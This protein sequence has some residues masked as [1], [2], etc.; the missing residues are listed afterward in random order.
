MQKNETKPTSHTTH[1]NEF[2]MDPRLKCYTQNHKNP[3]ENIG[4]KIS[5]I[6]HSN[7]LSDISPQA[8]ETKNKNKQRRHQSSH[9]FK[10]VC[11]L[12]KPMVNLAKSDKSF[13]M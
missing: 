8:R 3:R 6:G 4:S 7:I 1:K 9:H 13:S 10:L 5:D 11:Y 12:N 2:K